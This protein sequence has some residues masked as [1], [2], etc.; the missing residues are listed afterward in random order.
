MP[1]MDRS[2]LDSL[3]SAVASTC[4]SAADCAAESMQHPL[5][6]SGDF[7]YLNT[8]DEKI[9]GAAS[10]KTL[11]C[12]R[13]A[14]GLR[15]IWTGCRSKGSRPDCRPTENNS[16]CFAVSGD[17]FCRAAIAAQTS[18]RS[19]RAKKPEALMLRGT[20]GVL[21]EG[22]QVSPPADIRDRPGRSGIASPKRVP[23]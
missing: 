10:T 11:A 3:A 6:T 13:I 7:L 17:R 23:G 9:N 8:Q 4:R 20:M 15:A 22:Q 12:S 21:H 1:A 19:R 18:D 16:T 14:P 5:E 2:D